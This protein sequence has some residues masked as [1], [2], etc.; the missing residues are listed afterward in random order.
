MPDF[1]QKF[2]K[3]VAEVLCDNC[4]TALIYHPCNDGYSFL[5]WQNSLSI[6]F[7]VNSVIDVGKDKHMAM[8]KRRHTE[9]A[10]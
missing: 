9:Y 1:S 8:A 3:F 7:C 5:P 2:G 6:S 10:R 4:D